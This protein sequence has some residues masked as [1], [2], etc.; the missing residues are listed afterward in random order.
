[1]YVCPGKIIASKLRILNEPKLDILMTPSDRSE[2]ESLLSLV[3]FI[4]SLRLEL[5]SFKLKL[6]IF[7]I[8]GIFKPNLESTAIP[9]L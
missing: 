7:L 9:I 4:F 2:G 6:F 8:T 5:I 3:K 1:M